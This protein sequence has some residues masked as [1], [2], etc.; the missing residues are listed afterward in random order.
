MRGGEQTIFYLAKGERILHTWRKGK[1]FLPHLPSSYARV[2]GLV[3]IISHE[4][5]VSLILLQGFLTAF[6]SPSSPHFCLL[7]L[8]FVF[9]VFS[10]VFFFSSFFLFF[11]H[12]LRSRHLALRELSFTSVRLAVCSS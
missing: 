2:G 9:P 12:F 5:A 3:L 10:S 11:F 4:S 8:A 6:F 1:I 7:F